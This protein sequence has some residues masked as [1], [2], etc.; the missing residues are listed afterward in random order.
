MPLALPTDTQVPMGRLSS[1][2]ISVVPR[3]QA[4]TGPHAESK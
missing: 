3:L 2:A 4:P 1:A